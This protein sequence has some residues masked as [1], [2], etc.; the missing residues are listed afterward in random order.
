MLYDDLSVLC[1]EKDRVVVWLRERGLL[2][3]FEG[4]CSEC[5]HGKNKFEEG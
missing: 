5:G 3:N 4:V 2:G 1:A